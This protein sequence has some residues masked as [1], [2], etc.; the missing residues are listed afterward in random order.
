MNLR[1]T[2]SATCA[3]LA[4]ALAAC[5]GSG[6][7]GNPDSQLTPDQATA[8]INGAPPQLAAIRKQAN[9]LLDGGIDA[10][11]ARL[12]G[13]RGTPVVVNNWASWCGPCRAEFP[14]FQTAAGDRGGEIAFL[15]VDSDDSEDAAKMFLGELPL[16]YPSY[17]DPDN[18]VKKEVFDSPVGIPN[19]AFY[20]SGG[21]RTYVHQGPYS[22]ED[23]LTADIDRYTG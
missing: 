17:V 5:G 6:D 15:G 19:T 14:M 9:E 18:E 13:L 23:Q 4:L 11:N 1:L 3:A 7:A 21:E 2:I 10:V 22:S 16:P 8:P 12:D 20:D